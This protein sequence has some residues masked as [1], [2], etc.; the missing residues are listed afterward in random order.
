MNTYL[1][2][3]GLMKEHRR[4]RRI[5]HTLNDLDDADDVTG[6]PQMLTVRDKLKGTVAVELSSI[7][8]D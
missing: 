2:F 3:S 5:K 8:C 1:L 7:G 4:Y 6:I